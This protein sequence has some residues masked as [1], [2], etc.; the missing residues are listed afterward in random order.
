MLAAEI[1]CRMS[2][3]SIRDGGKKIVVFDPQQ[4]WATPPKLK[5]PVYS[6]H[7]LWVATKK[8]ASSTNSSLFNAAW[9]KAFICEVQ[10]WMKCIKCHLWLSASFVND[11][12]ITC[13]RIRKINWHCF[14]CKRPISMATF[15]AINWLYGFRS[16]RL[17]PGSRTYAF[18]TRICRSLLLRNAFTVNLVSSCTTYSFVRMQA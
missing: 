10:S 9:S 14:C 1:T 12:G 18:V 16:I 15:C 2:L 6:T 13:L 3:T 5:L 7:L 4:I 8:R 11:I 17:S